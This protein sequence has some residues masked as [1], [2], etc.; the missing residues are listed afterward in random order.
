V[1]S[2][3]RSIPGPWSRWH[4][5][6]LLARAT[7]PLFRRLEV[8]EEWLKLVHDA[9][10]RGPLVYVLRNLS[11]LDYLALSH[12]T[13]RLDLPRIGFAN[14][15]GP[16]WAPFMPTDSANPER[17]LC[18]TIEAGH[19]AALFLK[20]GP[21]RLGSGAARGRRGADTL[22]DALI[23]LQ[24][25]A[26][27]LEVMMV[28][29]TFV[30]TQRPEKRGAS[31]VDT[32]FGPGDYPGNVRTAA[33]FI[34]N[35]ANGNLRAGEA[36][37]LR[38]FLARP[39]AQA[40]AETRVNRLT[41][42]LL[43]KIE[44]ERRSIVGPPQKSPERVQ[45]EVLRSPKLQAVIAELAG[46]SREGQRLLRG[47]ARRMLQRMQTIPDNEVQRTMALGVEALIERVFSGVDVDAEGID[48]LR[49][50]TQRGP[51]ILLPSHKSHIDY[52]V[53]ST[54]LRRHALQLPAIAAG[55][56]LAF[57][58]A[59]PLL[60]RGGAFFIRRTFKNDRLYGALVDA[61][62]RRLLRE[63]WM[64][65]FF[66][67]GGRSRTG[68][69]LAPKTGLL[70]MVVAAALELEG[71]TVTFMPVSVGYERLMEERAFEREL[72]GKPKESEDATALLRVGGLLADRWGRIN[73]QFGN[74]L[75]I[76]SIRDLLGPAGKATSPEALRPAV[77]RLAY[78]VMS[79]INRVTALTPGALVATVLLGHGR[80][81]VTSRALAEQC[82]RLASLLLRRGARATP[83]LVAPGSEQIRPRAILDALALYLKAGMLEQH[84]PGEG[85]TDKSGRSSTIHPDPEVIFTVP[86]GKRLRV[87]LAKNTIVHLLVDRALVAVA[88]LG[89][90]SEPPANGA[91]GAN[92]AHGAHDDDG[93]DGDDGE[94]PRAQE[95]VPQVERRS[96]SRAELEPSLVALH[97]RVRSLSR[98]FKY[99]FMFR[100]GLTFDA[101]FDD[102][103]RDMV[104]VGELQTEGGEARPGPGHDGLDGAGW[105]RFYAATVRNFLEAYRVAARA[106]RVLVRGPLGDRELST[107]ALRVGERM[108]LQGEIERAEA[109]SRPMIENAFASFCDQGYLEREG[110]TLTLA[111][112]FDS[113]E[114][115]RAIEARVAAFLPDQPP[116]QLG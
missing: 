36:L 114:A 12:L 43:R 31:L 47:K 15:P 20:R 33:Q 10:A 55:D 75:G 17:L 115:V 109:V 5:D 50:A 67:E 14:A 32:I 3:L 19:S 52:L 11:L 28:P 6:R 1:L 60:R 29:L 83:S 97:D 89:V 103:V 93:D 95:R 90:A 18:Q 8:D 77:T 21:R 101:I 98:L 35:F 34:L 102:L 84:L 22:L 88:L 48:R 59:G 49:A 42:Q 27:S 26:P 41:Y 106:L 62:V 40:S 53:V 63:G 44:R 94:P 71:Q 91:N 80:R 70:G 96:E 73:L 104:A 7:D 99:E 45:V 54:V 69:L 81:G 111:A 76:D 37:S 46:P 2:A 85:L 30:W 113:E 68:K 92:G 105:L 16:S 74:A 56:N 79:E 51:V 4:P 108:F 58:P 39:E 25:A 87:D 78:L 72:S 100:A 65:E 86:D 112:S 57:F 9:A 116:Q 82:Q 110:K 61:Y 66:L 107:R 64:I 23:E 38:E 13:H 24:N